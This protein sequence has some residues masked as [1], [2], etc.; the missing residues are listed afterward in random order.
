MKAST[1]RTFASTFSTVLVGGTL[2]LAAS[3][4]VLGADPPQAIELTGVVRDFR[5]RSD[6]QGHPDF[7]RK[8]DLGFG[9]YCGNIATYV[10]DDRKPIFTGEGW[11][12]YSQWR[13]AEGRPICYALYDPELGDTPG[14]KGGHSAGGI[15][16]ADSFD[17][18]FRDVLGVNM[19]APAGFTLTFRLQPDGSYVFDDKEDPL[20]QELG[21]FFPI[22]HQLFGNPGGIP[23]RNFHFT[24]ELHAEFTYD[25]SGAQ[26]FRFVGDDDV[27][28][29]IDGKL[30]IDLGGV[31]AATEQYV[32]LDRLGLEDGKT[33]KLDFFFAERHRTQSNF[34]VVTNLVLHSGGIP[35][36]TA[37]Y[38]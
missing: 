30:V 10:D 26:E 8:P 23:D 25:A 12:V 31:H 19:S 33:Y 6:P 3:P 16:S 17:Q 2:G 7:E 38:D 24:L 9:H 37:A 29:Y 27:W 4:S 11:K 36:V 22:E 32:D 15:Q 18:W 34:R 21:G 35:P 14:I 13:D 5:E 1:R 20:Y 28:V